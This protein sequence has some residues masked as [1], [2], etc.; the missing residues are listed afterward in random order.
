[1]TQ[2]QK[3]PPNQLAVLQDFLLE[4][5]HVLQE[6]APDGVNVDKIIKMA[7]F[8][9]AKNEQ[10]RSCTPQSMF[11]AIGKACE[12]GLAAGGV[13]HRASL[14]P[15]YSKKKRAMEADLW[16]EYT[17]LMDLV[18]RSGEISS[19]VARVV[20]E[21]EEFEHYF[22]ASQGE[23]LRHRPCY[24]SDPGGLRLAYAVAFYKDGRRQIEVMRRDQILKI[25][26]GSRYNGSGP[27]KSHEEEM[28]RKTVI[29]RI[30]KYLPLTPQAAS[31]I[32]EDIKTE[33]SGNMDLMGNLS[34]SATEPIDVDSD[35]ID[36]PVDTVAQ[37][38]VKKA[39]TKTSKNTTEDVN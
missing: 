38:A 21:N 36:E 10:L 17:G 34:V 5:K 30:C 4:R 32:Q 37:A 8:E 31:V 11:M 19:F 16:V 20:H 9:A 35:I 24:D 18:R 27:W 28:W 29:R 33:F 7:I 26:D 6:L 2:L 25:R 14:V 13:L 15:I 22:D 39:K 23:I 1:M 12:L 3:Q